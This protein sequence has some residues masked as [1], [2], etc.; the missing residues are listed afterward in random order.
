MRPELVLPR[1]FAVKVLQGHGL[2]LATAQR[3]LTEARQT[4]HTLIPKGNG[5]PV[6]VLYE[7]RRYVIR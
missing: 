2:T 1:R 4:G 3:R 7:N 5:Y 6:F